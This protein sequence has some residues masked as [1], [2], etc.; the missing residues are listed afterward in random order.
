VNFIFTFTFHP[1]LQTSWEH[2]EQY[3]ESEIYL[4]IQLLYLV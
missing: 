4:Q 2:N 3:K 1:K